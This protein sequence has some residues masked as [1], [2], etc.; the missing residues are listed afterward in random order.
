[1]GGR[2]NCSLSGAQAPPIR[3]GVLESNKLGSDSEPEF[4]VIACWLFP[5]LFVSLLCPVSGGGNNCVPTSGPVI[6]V[7]VFLNVAVDS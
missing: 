3:A 7:C 1:M 2:G 5:P 4:I 6:A